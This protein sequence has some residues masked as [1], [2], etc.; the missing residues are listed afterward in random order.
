MRIRKQMRLIDWLIKLLVNYRYK[1]EPFMA[2]TWAID[3][4][5]DINIITAEYYDDYYRHGTR[6]EFYKEGRK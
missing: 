2:W 5:T 6:T 3:E 1:K 4:H